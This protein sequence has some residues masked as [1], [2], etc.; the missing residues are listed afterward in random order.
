MVPGEEVE[1]PRHARRRPVL[2]PHVLS[3]WLPNRVL[4]SPFFTH[5]VTSETSR[6]ASLIIE[7]A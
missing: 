4:I 2:L 5:L 3:A 7:Y 6:L 1:V